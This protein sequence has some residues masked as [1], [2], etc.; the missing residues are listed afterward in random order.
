MDLHKKR[1]FSVFLQMLTTILLFYILYKFAKKE[2]SLIYLIIGVLIFLASMFYRFRILTKNFYVQR[3]RKTKVLEFLSKTLPIFAFFAILY[4]PDI[5]G[6]NA[7]IGAIMF[8]SSLII[9][10]R[11]TKYY[12]QEEYDEYMKNKKKKNNKKKTKSKNESGK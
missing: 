6:I 4:I 11:Y 3:F 2:I 5:Y 7:I 1:K 12:T 10:E 8:N 9:D